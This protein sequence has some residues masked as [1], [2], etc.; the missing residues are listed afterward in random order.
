[1]ALGR[2]WRWVLGALALVA[3]MAWLGARLVDG[4]LRRRIERNVNASLKGYRV[5]IGGLH[6]HPLGF[7]IDLLEG[8]IVQ[9]SF[10]DPPIAYVPKLSASVQWTQ[11]LRGKLVAD[12]QFQ[13]PVF[14]VDLWRAQA[15]VKDPTPV[16]ERGW[17]E[18]AFAI[19]P[20]KI[21]LLEIEDGEVTYSAPGPFGPLHLEDLDF[22][23]GNIR[24]V[25]SRDRT[26]PSDVHLSA[27]LQ[28]TAHLTLDGHADF[29]AVPYAGIDAAYDVDDLRLKD[30]EPLL[31][32]LGVRVTKG[33]FATK[34]KIEYGPKVRDIRV[35]EARVQ[36]ADLTYVRSNEAQPKL[37]E[38]GAKSAAEVTQQ[39]DAAVHAKLIAIED[40][41]L[42]YLNETTD[43]PYRVFLTRVHTE[44]RDF[45]NVSAGNG[46]PGTARVRARF[47]DGGDFRI[48]TTF[49][50]RPERTDLTLSLAIEP[51]DMRRMNDLWRAYGNFDVE[52][53]ELAVYSELTVQEG[54]VRGYVK[55]IMKDVDIL[56]KE[57][58][59]GIG[60][61][62]YEG[63]VGGVATVLRNQ[64]RD[65]VATETDLS[66]PLQNPDTSILD[67][68][69][70]I[71]QNA[72]FQAILPGLERDDE[73]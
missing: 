4:P 49:R 65:Q 52:R 21:N 61:K 33:R 35:D 23:A 1:M 63:L 30:L 34:G 22:R 16:D 39:P 24:N 28:K 67:A 40:S 14:Y 71:I 69:G 68:L 45:S 5:H 12:F 37:G 72:F 15:E 57:D 66:G 54:Q 64:P 7:S 36:G 53:G 46:K 26:Y 9:E 38:V 44:V 6:F 3:V 47:M 43:P 62:I 10:P 20:L 17:Q 27:T 55:P 56:G 50:P 25:H 19:F 41:K 73:K 59:D 58:D 42:A 8:V 11:L 13:D 32:P 18:A 31:H 60:E 29:L 2:R 51:T 70:G 48:D